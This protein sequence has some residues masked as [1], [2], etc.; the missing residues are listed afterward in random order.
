ML[1]V[2]EYGN[3]ELLLEA[4][5]DLEAPRR[6]NVLQVDPAEPRRHALNHLHYLVSVLGVQTYREGVH[7][8]ELLEEH[9]LA[10]HHRHRCLGSYV[11]QTQHRRTVGDDRHGVSLDGE[12]E[13]TLG[14]LHD[15]AAHPRNPRRVGHGEVVA[16]PHRRLRPHLYLA[17]KVEEERPVGEVGYPHLRERVDRVGYL[18]SVLGVAGIHSEVSS[19]P[20]P[21]DSDD[22][23]RP[24]HTPH[25]AHSR[26]DLAER[27]RLVRKLNP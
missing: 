7:T 23:N 11:S 21:T 24:D 5:L 3:L 17:P 12:V 13:G 1:V 16:C 14:L 19:A 27:T 25:L 4:L 9:N 15:G 20:L 26:Q 8:C 2:V 18:T 22:V 10:L 6:R